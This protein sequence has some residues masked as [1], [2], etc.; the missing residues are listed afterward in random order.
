MYINYMQKTK[1]LKK[2][3][4]HK[5]KGGTT[6]PPPPPPQ[7]NLLPPPPPPT[8]AHK[9]LQ[10]PFLFEE[11]MNYNMV[12]GKIYKHPDINIEYK[13]I[14]EY[15]DNV[16]GLSY[17]FEVNSGKDNQYGVTLHHLTQEFI[18]KFERAYGPRKKTR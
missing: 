8:N 18:S 3:R 17:E 10:N 13:F 12:P 11:I 1:K 6:Q 2:Q 16:H 7:P 14:T 5:N 15:F 4:N 9:V